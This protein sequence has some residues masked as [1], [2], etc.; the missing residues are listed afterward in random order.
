V[1]RFHRRLAGQRTL[2]ARGPWFHD[3]AQVF[4]IG[5][6]YGPAADLQQG[7]DIIS[8]ALEAG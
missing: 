4:R 6:A 3:S 1:D 5:F 7:L 2:V 8:A